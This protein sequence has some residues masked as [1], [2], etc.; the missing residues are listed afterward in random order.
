MTIDEQRMLIGMW[1]AYLGDAAFADH[2]RNADMVSFYFDIV[3][4]SPLYRFGG[5]YEV[6]DVLING[7]FDTNADGLGHYV[8]PLKMDRSAA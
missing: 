3:H 7:P 4:E 1:H 5:A 8:Q 6:F 2:A